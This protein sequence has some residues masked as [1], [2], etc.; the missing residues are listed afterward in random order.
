[1]GALCDSTDFGELGSTELAEVC[2]VEIGGVGE[3]LPRPSPPSASRSAE[4]RR[5]YHV[6]D[7]GRIVEILFEQPRDALVGGRSSDEDREEIRVHSTG[8]R[9]LFQWRLNYLA[10]L[11][12][13]EAAFA[14][15]RR[16]ARGPKGGVAK[17]WRAG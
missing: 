8:L 14:A 3:D 5:L 16:V 15:A 10:S 6:K 9:P 4:P 7:P 12:V 2:G 17:R 1:L 13:L 11:S